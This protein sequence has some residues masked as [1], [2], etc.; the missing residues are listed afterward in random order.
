MP[1]SPPECGGLFQEKL[2]DR[3]AG[4]FKDN[5]GRETCSESVKRIGREERRLSTVHRRGRE[6]IFSDPLM[7]RKFHWNGTI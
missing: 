3:C 2:G 5:G 1:Q 6:D 7:K 4:E